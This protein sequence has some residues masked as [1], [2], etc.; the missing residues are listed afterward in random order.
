[1]DSVSYLNPKDSVAPLTHDQYNSSRSLTIFPSVCFLLQAQ[2]A[3][4]QDVSSP[5]L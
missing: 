4:F 3:A 2:A 1:M 5:E